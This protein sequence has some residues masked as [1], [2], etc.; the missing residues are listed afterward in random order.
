M[1]GWHTRPL[2]GF[3]LETTSANPEEARIVQAA[4]V[5]RGWPHTAEG[6][7]EFTTADTVWMVN[8]GCEVPEE[9][10]AIHGITTE[11]AAEGMDPAKALAQIRAELIRAFRHGTVI[12]FNARYDLTV[13]D[14]ESRRHRVEP[15]TIDPAWLVIDP[16]IL[17]KHRDKY[18]KG[19]R[20]LVDQCGHH[21]VTMDGA[22]H[23]ATTD[24][25]AAMRV[26]WR[27]AQD[28]HRIATY[29]APQLMHLQTWA[30]KDQAIS[31]AEHFRATG[32]EF[33]P[34]AWDWPVIPADPTERHYA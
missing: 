34:I 19:S 12:V 17:D 32:Q 4:L 10:A 29:A 27:I 1:T 9:A 11:R 21:R 31:L 7:G 20:R 6:A 16:L 2:A 14:R 3:D 30:A 5:R 15:L 8:P 23:D 22:A 33:E 24:A 28:N 18:R 25:L 26:G 13:L